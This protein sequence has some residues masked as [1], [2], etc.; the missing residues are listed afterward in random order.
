[1]N[2]EIRRAGFVNKGAELMLHAV[3]QQI[4]QKYPDALLAMAPIFGEGHS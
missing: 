2:I 1:M 3:C 4:R